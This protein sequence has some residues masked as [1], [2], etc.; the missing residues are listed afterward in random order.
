M[1]KIIRINDTQ[2]MKLDNNIGWLLTYKSQFGHDIVPDIMP[3][4]SSVMDL[5]VTLA[6][7][8]DK[9]ESV[10]DMLKKLDSS[11]LM[12]ALIEMAGLQLTDFVHILWAMAKTA[13]DKIP[14]PSRWV[15]Q[16]D[17][18]PLDILVPEAGSMIVQGMVSEKNLMS[19][20]SLVKSLQAKSGL[21]P[22]SSQGQSEG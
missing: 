17:S 6:G 2:E 15:R 11:D 5:V 8:V 22:S 16:F 18:F 19:L 20:R 12:S 14:E 7:V 1:E 21:T 9:D 10:Q 13:D 4:I 3:L